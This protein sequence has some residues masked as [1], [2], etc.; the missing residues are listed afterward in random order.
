MLGPVDPSG[1]GLTLTHEHLLIDFE[2]VF[3]PPRDSAEYHLADE[4][5]SLDNL[6]WVRFN[7][8]SN[9]DNLQLDNENLATTEADH[10]LNAGGKTIVDATSIGLSRNPRA[11]QP[12][13]G[14][15]AQRR[16]YSPA[17]MGNPWEVTR[18]RD[19]PEPSAARCDG[20][21]RR[22]VHVRPHVQTL[23][24]QGEDLLRVQQL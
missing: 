7:W 13:Q 15:T 6:G 3:Q 18:A 21:L 4:K 14:A 24:K 10:F 17:A 23:G 8:A 16:L 20:L 22:H 12:Q 2:V 11:L 19:G 5:L 1:L 9:H